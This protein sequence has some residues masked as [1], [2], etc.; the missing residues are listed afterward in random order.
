MKTH[1]EYL[2]FDTSKRQERGSAARRCGKL[3]R[4]TGRLD[5]DGFATAR[6][7]SAAAPTGVC[8]RE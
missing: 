6:V 4:S 1:T 8:D 5:G 3:R 2:T 7:P